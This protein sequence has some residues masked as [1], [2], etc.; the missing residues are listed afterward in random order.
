MHIQS[1]SSHQGEDS[2]IDI[3]ALKSWM[4]LCWP[5]FHAPLVKMVS[6]NVTSL[7]SWPG[8]LHPTSLTAIENESQL[9]SISVEGTTFFILNP[10]HVEKHAMKKCSQL[11]RWS[12]L[13]FLLVIFVSSLQLISPNW[14]TWSPSRDISYEIN[15]SGFHNCILT[16]L[17]FFDIM[18][19]SSLIPCLRCLF[20]YICHVPKF[21]GAPSFDARNQPIYLYLY[22]LIV[23]IKIYCATTMCQ[24]MC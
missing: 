11:W 21:T 19:P 9:V 15:K 16:S 3:S 4:P 20:V 17:I 1:S 8:F 10:A 6:L 12:H 7:H 5:H 22:S 24:I 18:L 13:L 23:I 14:A 2:L